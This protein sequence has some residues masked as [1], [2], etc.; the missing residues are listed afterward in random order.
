V[1]VAIN[2][3]DLL[4]SRNSSALYRG[5]RK[6][7]TTIINSSFPSP[8]VQE[9]LQSTTPPSAAIQSKRSRFRKINKSDQGTS[10]HTNPDSVAQ[11][12]AED[13]GME[14]FSVM[15]SVEELTALW[16]RRLPNAMIVPLSAQN[17][18]D[19]D[20]LVDLLVSLLPH[21]RIAQVKLS[22]KRKGY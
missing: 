15:R 3:I 8:A 12:L 9:Y 20:A 19:V 6:T 7:E 4:N 11:P 16:K 17:A 14:G 2:K 21:V 1:I 5:K 22:G 18:S 13:E 10:P